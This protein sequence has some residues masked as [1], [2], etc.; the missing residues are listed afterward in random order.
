M[1]I[2]LDLQRKGHRFEPYSWFEKTIQTINRPN[3]LDGPWEEYKVDTLMHEQHH[4]VASILK[5]RYINT[6][7]PVGGNRLGTKCA[8]VS[9]K[10]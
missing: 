6:M 1:V 10:S 7:C 8:W 3:I 4:D 9:L 5:R 2:A